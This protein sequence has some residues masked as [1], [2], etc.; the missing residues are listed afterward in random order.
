MDSDDEGAMEDDD[1]EDIATS[2]L[3]V[4]M[5]P[6]LSIPTTEVKGHS[7]VFVNEPRLSDFKQVLSKAGILAEFSGGVLICN[8]IVAIRRSNGG[9]LELEGPVCDE[10]YQIRELLYKQYA[11]V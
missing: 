6:D 9:H 11:I 7:A 1:L 3:A 2:D 10:F 8:S 5:V 4:G